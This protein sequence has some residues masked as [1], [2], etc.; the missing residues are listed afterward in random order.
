MASKNF[1]KMAYAV[2]FYQGLIKEEIDYIIYILEDTG[3]KYLLN[4]NDWM[5][6]R[7]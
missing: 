3:Q 4:K 7:Q 1:G 5:K 6:L 2:N